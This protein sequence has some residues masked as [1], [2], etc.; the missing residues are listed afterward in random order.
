MFAVHNNFFEA[1]P[2]PKF[3]LFSLHAKY[4]AAHCGQKQKKARMK[5][6]RPD[7]VSPTF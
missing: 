2:Q 5:K 1:S 6:E 3:S 4:R 7:F